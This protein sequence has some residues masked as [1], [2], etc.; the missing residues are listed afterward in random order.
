MVRSFLLLTLLIRL[1]PANAQGFIMPRPIGGLPAMEEFFEQELNYPVTALE[2]GIKGEVWLKL[3]VMADGSVSDLRVWKTLEATCDQEAM[4]LARLILWQPAQ[5][6]DALVDAEHT[7]VVAFDPKRYRRTLKERRPLDPAIAEIPIMNSVAV[8]P[9]S[10]VSDPPR[11][12]IPGGASGFPEWCAK[13]LRYPPEAL[14]RS[15]QG[16]VKVRFVVEP[17]G[18]LSNMH[19]ISELGGGC[20]AE[21]MR[22]LRDM[23]WRPGVANGKR[24]RTQME[25]ELIF[26]LP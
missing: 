11:P 4:R 24:L 2:K 7:V 15:I 13:N 18:N 20:V 8:H 14:R 21:A 12:L 3:N 23:P 16:P 5:V 1:I 25:M 26:R 22:M 10:H 17:S 19:A 9:A 6:G